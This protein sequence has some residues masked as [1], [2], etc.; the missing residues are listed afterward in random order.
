MEWIWKRLAHHVARKKLEI[1]FTGI[2]GEELTT[3]LRQEALNRLRWV[4]LVIFSDE[5][6]DH[7]KVESLRAWFLA[8][9]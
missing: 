2:T 5:I 7:E 9:E 8:E 1:E 4:E 3:A 6:D